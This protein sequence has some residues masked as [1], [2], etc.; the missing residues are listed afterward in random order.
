VEGKKK[1]EQPATNLDLLPGLLGYQVRLAQ[2]AIFRN[3]ASVFDRLAI[4]PG[5]FGVLVIIASNP[6]LTQNRLAAATHLDRSTVV[7][8]IDKLEARGLVERR[9]AVPDRRAYALTLTAAGGAL[10]RKLKPMVLEHE[11]RL[12]AGLSAAESATLMRLLPKIFPE[13][14]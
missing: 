1:R 12:S 2:I 11:R 13:L 10:L 9:P 3:F 8:V 7:T 4:S 5:L 14:R 6:G